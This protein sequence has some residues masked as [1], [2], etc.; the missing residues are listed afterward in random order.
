M[1]FLVGS[2]AFFKNIK[3]FK[4]KDKDY[5]ILT[6]NPTGFKFQKEVCLR[7]I[8]SFYYKN[9][10]PQNLIKRTLEIN[11]P[12]LV[13]K[14]LVPEVAKAIDL[15]IDD[16]KLLDNLIHKV[17]NKHKYQII[18]YESILQNNSFDLTEEQ[19]MKAYDCYLY[20]RKNVK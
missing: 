7:G 10:S 6:D 16:L 15:S 14:F 9:D 20:H 4:S 13:G 17:D 8:D 1:K 19:I 3:S 5:L 2:N 18:I 11:D 12:M